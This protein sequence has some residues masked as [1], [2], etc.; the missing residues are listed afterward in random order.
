MGLSADIAAFVMRLENAI[1]RTMETHVADTAKSAM[2]LAVEDVV[3]DAYEPQGYQRK[4]RHGGLADTEN[5][6]TAYDRD[7]MTLVLKNVRTDEITGKD[8]A[9]TVETGQGYDYYSLPP[10]RFYEA[11][12]EMLGSG[13]FEHALTTGLR[14]AGFDVKPR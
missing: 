13:T 7:T 1:H 10:R 2:Q 9:H 11:T 4:G 8:V 12:E 5:M 3:Y 6:E 14:M